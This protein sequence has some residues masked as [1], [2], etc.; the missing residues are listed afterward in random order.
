MPAPAAATHCALP[1]W[2]AKSGT[3]TSGTPAASVPNVVPEPP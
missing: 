1:G 3:I 2:S